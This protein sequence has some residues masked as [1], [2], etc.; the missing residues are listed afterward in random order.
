MTLSARTLVERARRPLWLPRPEIHRSE[1]G[2]VLLVAS[3]AYHAVE[4]VPLAKELRRR[5]CPVTLMTTRAAPHAVRQATAS[6]EGPLY[7]WPRVWRAVPPFSAAVV[8]ND[9]GPTRAL[10][11]LARKRGIPSFAKVEGVQDFEDVDTRRSRSPYRCVDLVLGQGANDVDAL[12]DE[13]VRVVGS[14]RL[15]ALW[16]APERAF[17]GGQPLIVINSNFTYGVLADARADWLSAVLGAADRAGCQVVISQHPAEPPLAGDLPVAGIPMSDLLARRADVLVSRFST[18]PF[19]AMAR[20]VPF[21]YFNPHG[22]RVPTFQEGAGFH[23]RAETQDELV[24]AIKKALTW[25]GSY[26]A[27]ARAFF[28][29]QVDVA[30]NASPAERAA[31]AIVSSLV[32]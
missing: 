32:A 11:L 18:V 16:K 12:G 7:A 2:G 5:G 25:R 26:R 1:F 17:G 14:E 23:A 10:V 24:D 21:V 20:G 15:E 3:A 8:M 13:R 27:R 19:E 22:E 31:D 6:W 28:L 29:R 4:L 9:W 30:D